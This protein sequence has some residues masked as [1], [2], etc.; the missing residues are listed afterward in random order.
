MERKK[1]PDA[2]IHPSDLNS[3]VGITVTHSLRI[4][5]EN[6]GIGFLCLIIQVLPSQAK[7]VS[8]VLAVFHPF[9]DLVLK[10]HLQ[11]LNIR[12]FVK[13]SKQFPRMQPTYKTP[14]TNDFHKTSLHLAKHLENKLLYLERTSDLVESSTLSSSLCMCRNRNSYVRSLSDFW[15]VPF[16]KYMLKK[17]LQDNNIHSFIRTQCKC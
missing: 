15:S 8:M 5:S 10:T 14:F 16:L 6:S 4:E 11:L 1:N 9:A 12:W 7:A 17:T 2:H 3:Q 13:L